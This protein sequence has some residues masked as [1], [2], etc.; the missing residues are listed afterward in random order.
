MAALWLAAALAARTPAVDPPGKA[1]DTRMSAAFAAAQAWQGPLDG[2]WALRDARGRRLL[3]LQFADP[4]QGAGAL[5]AAWRGGDGSL[6]VVDTVR[7]N[8]RRLTLL[9]A[10]PTGLARL[11]LRRVGRRW[12]GRLDEHDRIR[13]VT[14]ER[15]PP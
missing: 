7:L 14:M 4:P 8:G 3:T 5:A 15:P 1:F 11:Q 13:M 12:R 10:G 6:G 9:Y 2:G